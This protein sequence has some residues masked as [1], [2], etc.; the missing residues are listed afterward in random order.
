MNSLNLTS[1][2]LKN[3]KLLFTVIGI[4]LFFLSSCNQAPNKE[5]LNK[6]VVDYY[7]KNK[8]RVYTD[9]YGFGYEYSSYAGDVFEITSVK[10]TDVYYKDKEGSIKV[11][12]SGYFITR[13]KSSKKLEFTDVPDELAIKLYDRGW[14]V[15]SEP[16]SRFHLNFHNNQHQI[17]R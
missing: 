10:I 5:V 17:R 9:A 6:E 2:K 14:K 4:T 11:L 15:S 12:V 7:M 3:T 13:D 16:M 1:I 8:E